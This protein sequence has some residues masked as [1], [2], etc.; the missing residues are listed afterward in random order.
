MC[1]K[2]TFDMFLMWCF[3]VMVLFAAGIAFPIVFF[4]INGVSANVISDYV[5]EDGITTRILMSADLVDSRVTKLIIN[6]TS[7][8]RIIYVDLD[9]IEVKCS[10]P[11][12]IT[13]YDT[14]IAHPWQ[15]S[16][17]LEDYCLDDPKC[18]RHNGC[19]NHRL[20]MHKT[21]ALGG[22]SQICIQLQYE[23]YKSY[24]Y[25]QLD[26][27]HCEIVG[28]ITFTEGT[29]VT[30]FPINVIN[31]PTTADNI[32][33]FV[34][35]MSNKLPFDKEIGILDT[36]L[37]TKQT[38]EKSTLC[39]FNPAVGCFGPMVR[40]LNGAIHIKQEPKERIIWSNSF[41]NKANPKNNQLDA[42]L[43]KHIEHYLKYE[44]NNLEDI[45]PNYKY[46][47]T[48]H[49]IRFPQ[50]K[51]NTILFYADFVGIY[52]GEENVPCEIVSAEVDCVGEGTQEYMKCILKIVTG[53]AV[54]T[55]ITFY[56]VDDVDI[57]ECISQ[58]VELPAIERDEGE[59][60][61][62]LETTDGKK[63]TG[64]TTP[65]INYPESDEWQDSDGIVDSNGDPQEPLDPIDE[66][67]MF[68]LFATITLIVSS[69]G[70]AGTIFAMFLGA[71]IYKRW[72][73]S[74]DYMRTD[75]EMDS[76]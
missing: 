11:P 15:T 59:I 27:E 67:K 48:S 24:Q 18:L 13:V 21:C 47:S 76:Y 28:N 53:H 34:S 29:T 58:T 30:S 43:N 33:V 50:H 46:N 37:T 1:K 26:P 17:I 68:Y 25:R 69:V 70:L 14:K 36:G 49:E 72:C 75:V 42:S 19:F 45:I 38:I 8:Q 62:V 55:D 40:L 44:S 54:G 10:S 16:C 2:C 23:I 63:Y 61:F 12:Y 31:Q 35:S 74:N 51:K 57:Y 32:S 56:W 64:K 20:Y 5:L 41:F 60:T 73:W 65:V 6:G 39:M 66:N 7:G 3:V 9:N 71:Y 4:S 22:L 52:A